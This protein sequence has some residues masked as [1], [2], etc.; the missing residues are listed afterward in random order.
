MKDFKSFNEKHYSC[1]LCGECCG[2]WNLPI[3]KALA[4]ELKTKT[5]VQNILKKK[6]KEF[7]SFNNEYLLP[8]SNGI[9]VFLEKNTNFCLLQKHYSDTRKPLECKRFPFAFMKDSKGNLYFDTSFYCKAIIEN[10]G[11]LLNEE[12]VKKEIKDFDLFTIPETVSISPSETINF[13]KYL[14]LTNIISNHLYKQFN[15]IEIE[16]W[17]IPLTCLYNSFKTITKAYNKGNITDTEHLSKH[18]TNN[19][20]KTR[21][22]NNRLNFL[23]KVLIKKKSPIID[24]IK[25]I[26]KT[27]QL[28]EP[29]TN[30]TIHLKQLKRLSLEN[31]QKTKALYMR[32]LLDIINRKALL[33][34]EHSLEGIILATI[35]A[36]KVVY[37]YSNLLSHL[38]NSKYIE[39][40]HLALAIRITERYYIG[41]NK[42]FMEIFRDKTPY[43]IM[44]S[45]LTQF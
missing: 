42:R 22:I 10:K 11:D 20:K 26:T 45:I 34:H 17:H 1:T 33:A 39:Y 23:E 12:Y 18:L 24:F 2:A 31:N 14:K 21:K 8:K 28:I 40:F 29:I 7:F 9:C 3:D 19:M 25:Y 35:I 36:L 44:K 15:T 5:L 43:Y 4:E 16:K 37:F 6:K 13:Q 41:H 27:G 32:F 38:D 30:E